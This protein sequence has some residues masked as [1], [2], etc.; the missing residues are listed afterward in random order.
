MTSCYSPRYRRA[1]IS[2]LGTRSKL[3][4]AT[5]I[6]DEKTA[7]FTKGCYFGTIKRACSNYTTRKEGEIRAYQ[8]KLQKA[9]K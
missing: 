2:F 3:D 6:Y 7:Q 9:K 4:H 8:N 1:G 5:F